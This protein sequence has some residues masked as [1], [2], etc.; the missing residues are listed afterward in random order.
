MASERNAEVDQAREWL[1]ANYSQRELSALQVKAVRLSVLEGV[2][3]YASAPPFDVGALFRR[4][5]PREPGPWLRAVMLFR[6]RKYFYWEREDP[7]VRLSSGASAKINRKIMVGLSAATSREITTTFGVE[8]GLPDGA[9][10]ISAQR[11]I[12]DMVSLMHTEQREDSREINLPSP[13]VGTRRYA[14]WQRPNELHVDVVSGGRER[15][16]WC[17][18]ATET[19]NITSTIVA[20]SDAEV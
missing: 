5:E 16:S 17:H 12:K 13:E 1:L 9:G 20:N 19:F 15:V 14:I 18:V 6:L 4:L 7:L 8:V 3:T 2:R 10:K 11:G